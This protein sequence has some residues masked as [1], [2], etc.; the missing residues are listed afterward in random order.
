MMGWLN[1]LAQKTFEKIDQAIHPR[2]TGSSI[3][4]VLRKPKP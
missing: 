2:E 1:K 3:K 4:E